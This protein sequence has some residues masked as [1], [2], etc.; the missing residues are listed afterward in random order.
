MS[1]KGLIHL[2]YGDGKGKTTAALGLAL[3]AAGCGKN[4]VIVEFIKNWSCGEHNAISQLSNVR[5]FRGKAAG[6]KF[7]HEMTK[8]EKQE[9]KASQD[10]CLKKAISLVETGECDILILDEAIDT[11]KLGMLDPEIFD[12]IVYNKPEPLELVITGHCSDT[13]LLEKADY[14]TEMLKHK[15]PYDKGVTARQGIEF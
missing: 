11:Y 3:R 9:T 8:E 10:D 1:K 7:V 5:F 2:Y 12:N 15:H 14:V 13:R 4:V 6:G